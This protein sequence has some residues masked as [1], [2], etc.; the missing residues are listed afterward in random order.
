MPKKKDTTNNETVVDEDSVALN[1]FH[2]YDSSD[3]DET[4]IVDGKPAVADF[5]MYDSKK[6]KAKK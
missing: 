2:T 3:D 4:K 6:K 5:H 1:S